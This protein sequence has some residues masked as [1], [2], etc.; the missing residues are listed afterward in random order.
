MVID[1]ILK[2]RN[3]KEFLDVSDFKKE[4][5]RISKLVHPDVCS[6]PRANQ[7]FTRFQELKNLFENGFSF[8]DD[9]GTVTI[10]EKT[11]EFDI[12]L[13][14]SHAS[15]LMYETIYKKA[16]ANFK[17][18]LPMKLQYN[19][20]DTDDIYYSLIDV[21]L[22]EEHVRWVLNRLL[23]FSAYMENL[24]YVHLGIN[25]N[26]FL[27]NPKNHAINVIS[28]YHTKPVGQKV[29]TISAKYSHWYP[30]KLF[31]EKIAKS[32]YDVALAKAMACQLLGDPSGRGVKLKGKVSDPLINFLLSSHDGAFEAMDD[33]KKM[34]KANYE[35]KFYE[36]NL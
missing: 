8:Q 20:I 7:A 27:V 23:E 31:T 2:A 33:Y 24:G 29:D 11:I 3:V 4:Y 5:I 17:K 18:Y 13:P 30:A 10:K 1:D 22:P 26:S 36:L 32:S 21:N 25:L 14:Q 34:L 28:F 9:A 12:D 6:D 16:N 35:S 15:T 19:V